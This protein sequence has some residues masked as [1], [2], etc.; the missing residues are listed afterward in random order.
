[1]S[2]ERPPAALRGTVAPD[3]SCPC[4]GRQPGPES[5]PPAGGRRPWPQIQPAIRAGTCPRPSG[6]QPSSWTRPGCWRAGW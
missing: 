3:A 4:R 2:M 5:P 6:W 1:M